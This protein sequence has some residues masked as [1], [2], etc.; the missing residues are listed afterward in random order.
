MFKNKLLQNY[1]QSMQFFIPF[2]ALV[3]EDGNSESENP[4]YIVVNKNLSYSMCLKIRFLDLDY[5]TEEEKSSKL[6]IFN[7]LIKRLPEGFVIHSEFQR[8]KINDT[9]IKR[10]YDKIPTFLIENRRKE[11]FYTIVY[12]KYLLTKDML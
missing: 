2:G 8:K 3:D 7:N 4:K 10:N 12:I 5:F 6:K 1:E 11:I 9:R